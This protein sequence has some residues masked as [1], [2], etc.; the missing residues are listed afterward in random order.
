[1]RKT[2]SLW[3]DLGFVIGNRSARGISIP[4]SFAGLSGYLALLSITA[5]RFLVL[6][7]AGGKEMVHKNARNIIRDVSF[8]I[9]IKRSWQNR[10][11][12]L[13]TARMLKTERAKVMVNELRRYGKNT[14]KAHQMRYKIMFK[15]VNKDI[16]GLTLNDLAKTYHYFLL[17]NIQKLFTNVNFLSNISKKNLSATLIPK[18]LITILTSIFIPIYHSLIV[19]HKFPC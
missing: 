3:S 1:M 18:V 11:S 9:W 5:L 17:I 19:I 14:K 12:Q 7:P 16:H 15:P 2:V 4:S 10:S 8:M 6:T 13:F